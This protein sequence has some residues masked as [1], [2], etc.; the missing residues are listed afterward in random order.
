M[1][2][3][4]SECRLFRTGSDFSTNQWRKGGGNSRCTSCVGGHFTCHVCHKPCG[5]AT[6]LKMH[7]QIHRDRN[8]SCPV[9][10]RGGFKSGADAVA[11]VESGSCSGCPGGEE[12]RQRIIHFASSK[13]QMEPYLTPVATDDETDDEDTSTI[14][15]QPYRCPQCSR[16]FQKLSSLLQ[17]QENVH[18]KQNLFLTWYI[19]RDFFVGEPCDK[20]VFATRQPPPTCLPL[21]TTNPCTFSSIHLRIKSEKGSYDVDAA[22]VQGDK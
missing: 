13:R 16:C 2:R 21:P 14:H 18:N 3:Q 4:C 17:H 19:L 1:G 22:I 5:N 6:N 7:M 9:C 10:G 8:V 20:G 12:A 15:D 11:H